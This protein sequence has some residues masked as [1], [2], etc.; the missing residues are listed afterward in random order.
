MMVI[1]SSCTMTAPVDIPKKKQTN[2]RE[3]L[4]NFSFK[5]V[6]AEWCWPFITQLSFDCVSFMILNKLLEK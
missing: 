6:S 1:A 5:L 2:G 3:V 4:S